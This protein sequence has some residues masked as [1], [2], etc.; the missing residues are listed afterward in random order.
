MSLE[1]VFLFFHKIALAE[2]SS[3]CRGCWRGCWK[4]QFC[5]L[6]AN[7]FYCC[8]N[9]RAIVLDTE[10]NASDFIGWCIVVQFYPICVSADSCEHFQ[11]PQ[12]FPFAGRRSDFVANSESTTLTV[13][14]E[15][16]LQ[17][18]MFFSCKWKLIVSSS[19]NQLPSV[20]TFL[21]PFL[22]ILS[23]IFIFTELQRTHKSLSRSLQSKVNMTHNFLI[24]PSSR[25]IFCPTNSLFIEQK[26]TKFQDLV[27]LRSIQIIHTTLHPKVQS[28][29]LSINE[30]ADLFSALTFFAWAC[31]GTCAVER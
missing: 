30:A 16:D 15:T 18:H 3:S 31:Q 21:M 5:F 17:Q 9:E 29:N 8:V 7:L 19:K 13:Q 12:N 23:S 1:T 27:D 28:I 22:V 26:E 14:G 25:P 2:Q 24:V 20:S 4:K 11:R 10:W 6:P